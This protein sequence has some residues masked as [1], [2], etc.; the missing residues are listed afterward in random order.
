MF[1]KE[2]ISIKIKIINSSFGFKKGEIYD[3]DKCKGGW[4]AKNTNLGKFI[5]EENAEEV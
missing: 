5:S 4:F 2:R 3:A 1:N